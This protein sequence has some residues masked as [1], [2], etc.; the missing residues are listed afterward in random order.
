MHI[1]IRNTNNILCAFVA[2]LPNIF[3]KENTTK[4][5]KKYTKTTLIKL[6]FLILFYLSFN[7]S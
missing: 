5:L 7:K 4:I 3:F 1:L 6:F 2:Y